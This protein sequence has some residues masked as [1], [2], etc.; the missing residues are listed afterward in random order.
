MTIKL[1]MLCAALSAP[2]LPVSAQKVSTAAPAGSSFFEQGPGKEYALKT[3]YVGGEVENPGPVDLAS[4]TVR[5]LAVK[6][7]AFAEGKPQFKGAYFFS[8]YSLYD[9]LKLKTVKKAGGDFHPEVDLFVVVENDKGEKAVFSWGE[10]FYA[11]NNFN[12]LIYKA[13][14]SITTGRKKDW[15]LPEESRLVCSDDLYNTRFIASPTKITVRSAPGEYPGEKH[16]EAYAPDFKI[17]A[18]GRAETIKDLEKLAGKRGYIYT[19]YGHGSGFKSVKSGEGFLF[20]DVL[21]KTAGIAP[22]D[23]GSSLV[24]VSAGD[25]YRAAFSLSE[26]INMGDNSDLL[27]TERGRDD[28]GRFSLYCPADFFVD[29]NVGSAAKVEVLKI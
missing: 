17:V 27:L 8:G 26:I 20:K 22:Q 14:R 12:A 23:S 4:L 6:E 5:D 2:V 24:I 28:G 9:I 18:G 1:L 13:A 15:P 3:I 25:A 29:R 11:R 10:I 16:K 7:L 21:A 19:G